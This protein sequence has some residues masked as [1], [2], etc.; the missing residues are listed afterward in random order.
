MQTAVQPPTDQ[1]A[2][3]GAYV[4]VPFCN[5]RC[6]YC[7]FTLIA[8]R[9][10]L[11]DAYLDCLERELRHALTYPRPVNTIFIGGG[12]PTF[13]PPAQLDALLKIIARWLPLQDS[14]E[15]S[16]EANPID[17]KPECLGLLRDAGVNRLSLGGQSF[18]DQKL[19]RLER[20]HTGNE[21][22]RAIELAS[23]FFDNLSVD[24]IFAV[25]GEKLTDWQRDLNIALSLPIQHLSNYGL[26]I[27]KGTTFFSRMLKGDLIELDADRQL[28]MY[29]AA[30]DQLQNAG[31]KHYEVSNFCQ[32]GYQCRH[33]V[34]YWS[35]KCWWGFGP[36]ASSCLTRTWIEGNF[37]SEFACLPIK[38]SLAEDR[39]LSTHARYPPDPA[40]TQWALATNHR[41]TTEY[42][43]R[44]RS[45]RNPQAEIE[46]LNLEQWIRQRLVFGLRQIDG[47]QLNELADLWG[48]SVEPLF[49][50]YLSHYIRQGWLRYDGP[51]LQLTR[52]GLVISDSLW[53]DL[54]SESTEVS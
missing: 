21:L 27:E 8:G 25:H 18:N 19:L 9:N 48:D 6:G 23:H 3:L 12:T 22:Q 30:I 20:D 26:T 35:G 29:L 50:P 5:R 47:I 39:G 11:V 4:H 31:W 28:D 24:L 36:G 17:C 15:Y 13:L 51:S 33:N 2:P 46:W 10:D 1:W 53:P 52:Q 34:G 42:I 38:S 37:G 7:N 45:G 54:L 40:V 14:G 43:K 44:I 16:C 49:E 32:P 41:S